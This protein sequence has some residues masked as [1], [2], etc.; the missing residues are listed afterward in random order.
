VKNVEAK[1]GFLVVASAVILCITVYY[2]S[3]AQWGEQQLP[4]KTYLRYAGGLEAGTQVLFGGMSVGKVTA[5][6][7]DPADPT[8]IEISLVVRRGTPVNSKSVAKLESTSLMSSPAI[9]ITTGSNEAPRLPAGAAIPSQEP[10]TMDEMERKVAALADSAQV[11]LASVRI[12]VDKLTGNAQNLLTNLNSLTGNANQK[13]VAAI[14]SNA[15]TMVA[16]VSAKIGPTVDNLNTTLANA[17]ATISNANGTISDL[18]EPMHA[19]LIELHRTLEETHDLVGNFHSLLRA[20]EQNISDTLENIR[21]A[22]DNLNDLSQSVKERPW[23]LVR[24]RQPK[25]REVP[26]GQ[27]K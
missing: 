3:N 24:I 5:L 17:N 18:R 4:Y 19:D 1:V 10:I 11:T 9:S 14:L 27:I 22:T 13:H 23:S 21:M 7:P 8:R 2:V 26:Q 15:D 6:R 25:G 20:N 16:Q 12:D